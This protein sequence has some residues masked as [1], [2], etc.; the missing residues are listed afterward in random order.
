MKNYKL[1][2]NEVVLYKNTVTLKEKNEH[3]NADFL[4]TNLNF[5]FSKEKKRLLGTKTYIDCFA[6]N[7]VKIYNDEPQIKQTEALVEIYFLSGEKT[8]LFQNKSEAHKFTLKALELITGKTA[9]ARGVAKV[10]KA[11]AN[12]DETLGFEATAIASTVI[13]AAANTSGHPIIAETIKTLSKKKSQ[14]PQQL[15]ESTQETSKEKQ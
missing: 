11:V 12:I 8:I 15:L 4:L 2:P 10:K 7:T 5:V 9:F 3:I 13:Q 1:Q 14:E 6:V